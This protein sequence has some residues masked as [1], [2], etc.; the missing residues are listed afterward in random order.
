VS[1]QANDEMAARY[2][3]FINSL[4]QPAA[5][6]DEGKVCAEHVFVCVCVD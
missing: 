6:T 5:P 3:A 2:A 4:R 1:P